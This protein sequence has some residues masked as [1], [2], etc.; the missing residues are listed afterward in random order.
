VSVRTY[1]EL[2]FG[3]LPDLGDAWGVKA[4]PHVL[5]KFKRLF[6]RA[7]QNRA[8]DILLKATPEVSR[9]LEW[10][11]TRYSLRMSETT[12]AH[13]A[14]EA[15]RHRSTE[16]AVGEILAGQRTLS[17]ELREP[18]RPPRGYQLQA[19]DVVLATGRLLL[20]DDVGLGKTFSSLL[21][22]RDPAALP[23]LVVTL[24]HLPWQWLD[25]LGKSLPWLHGH[26]VTKGQPYNPAGRRGS[27]GRSPDVLI[28]GYS[29]LA[30]WADHLA[31]QV[32]TVIFD[33]I[34]EL[35]R[36]E[37]SAKG[38][39]AY[40]VADKAA[41]RMGL[42]VG[43]DSTVELAGGPFG[44]GWVGRIE[45]A[46][47][48]VAKSASSR[49]VGSHEIFDV[50]G[51]D[52]RSRGWT[53]SGFAWKPVKSFI[54][55]PC[56]TGV[57]AIRSGSGDLLLTG[58]HAVY[59][60]GESDLTLSRAD[61]VSAGD[62][63]A[64]DDG[65]DW[66][67]QVPE[68]PVDMIDV[69]SAL[70]NPQV[71]VGLTG[72]TRDDLGVTAWEWQNFRK[73]GIHGTRLP[74]AIYSRHADI[75]PPPT[76]VYLSGGR[77]GRLIRPRLLLSDWAYVLG[78]YLGD[79][80]VC[81]GRVCF[82]VESARADDFEQKVRSLP[83]VQVDP[84]VRSM[85][86]D[87]VEVRF[88]HPIVAELLRRQLG[89]AK[90]HEK[91]IPG[92][93]IISWPEAARRQL[94]SGLLDSDGHIGKRAGRRYYTTTSRQ[95][96]ESLLSLLRSLGITGSLSLR[97]PQAGGI[98]DGRRITGRRVGYV[99]NW[100]AHAEA[101]SNDQWRGARTR[102]EWTRGRLH[103]LP[104]RD[105]SD[106]ECV[107][108]V[109]Y[110][111]E[112]VGHPS[113]V[114][115]GVLVHNSAT[116]VFNYGGEI[117]NIMG[118]LAP[119][120]L[121]SRDE[122]LREWGS[123]EYGMARHAAVENPAALGTYLRDQGLLLRRTRKDVHREIPEPVEVEQP[124]D[125]DHA[126]IEQV[127]ADV[128]HTARILLGETEATGT[129]RFQAAGEVDWRMR[130]ATGVAKAAYVA[131]FARLLLES[132]QRIVLFGWHRDVYD[133]W[134]DLLAAYHPVLYTGTESPQQK[135]RSAV[136]F[137][138]GQSRVLIMS[139]RS[140]AGLDG[141][142]D[143]CSV[144]VFGE[145]DWSPEIHRQCTGRLARDGQESTVIAYYMVSDDGTDPLMAEV[146]GI[147]KQQAEPIRDPGL[148]LFTALTPPT[149]RARALAAAV[150]SRVGK[151]GGTRA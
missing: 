21:V 131:E 61:A 67:G 135:A 87:S 142:Q 115:N 25:E 101:G 122:F 17:G 106:V 113:F 53:G 49:G 3:T 108:E 143:W 15:G 12:A 75:L 97:R 64:S 126:T 92:E 14:A 111:L 27:G 28:M 91:A 80:W 36:G 134:L 102:Y 120:A 16:V 50:E 95:L 119:D 116:P 77:G 84:K 38:R 11:I 129:E 73:E 132:E 118:A 40:R 85:P 127:A 150:L 1:G 149:D 45:D 7:R 99:V 6:P 90:C 83:G 72:V 32:S 19:A 103:E 78:F 100:S 144:A 112:M 69:A 151:S 98:V 125:T 29:K 41:Y 139:L 8:G 24:T 68:V 52:I 66:S 89:G 130:Q 110:D 5:I 146:L 138:G 57:R 107:P 13:L 114:A 33:E 105:A 124:V 26:V 55:H 94:L 148:P 4:E 136:A 147:K 22:L 74:A 20:A 31:G 46:T 88:G 128:A 39:A 104:V 56:T 54:Q 86:G 76:G 62:R 121:G 18:A 123:G 47:A 133:I 145:L 96:A 9:D 79:G 30:G 81:G 140:G 35:R 93:W 44:T 58:E 71:V 137:K 82:A 109:V 34:Q 48:L 63:L 60:V 59:C 117:H 70:A 65:G 10:F 141:L 51:L 23:A 37:D 42:S 43:P 2:R